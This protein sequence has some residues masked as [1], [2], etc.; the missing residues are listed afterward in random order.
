MVLAPQY[1]FLS[2][3]NPALEKLKELN[4]KP[5]TWYLTELARQED[6]LLEIKESVIDPI[7]KFMSGPQKGIFD[8]ARKFIDSQETN[9]SYVQTQVPALIQSVLK[10]PTCFKG[11]RIQQIKSDLDALMLEVDQKVNDVRAQAI[12]KLNTLQQRMHG[13]EEFQKLP[14]VRMTELD[15]PYQELIAHIK[16]QGLIAVINDRLRYFEEQ[17]YQKLLTKLNDLTTVGKES[18][19]EYIASRHIDIAFDKAWLADEIDVDRYLESMRKA[20]LLEIRNGKII[21]I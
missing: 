8:D 5:Y 6:S 17:G 4:G 13:L 20:L 12:E 15:A 14:D 2:A 7:R 19:A 16:Q 1:P 21:Q 11:N 18:K 3:L 9:F 10:D